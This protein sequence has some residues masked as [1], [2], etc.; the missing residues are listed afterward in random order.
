MIGKKVISS[1]F[2]RFATLLF[3]VM[4]L[5]AF[6]VSK[7]DSG[8]VPVTTAY[9]RTGYYVKAQTVRLTPSEGAA[10][11]CTTDGTTPTIPESL[12]SGPV[13]VDRSLTLKFFAVDAYGNREEMKTETYTLTLTGGE[14]WAWGG[15]DFGH[16]GDGTTN[17]RLTPA[18]NGF[19]GAVSAAAGMEHSVAL[20]ADGTVW[21][22]GYNAYGQ[23]G[24]GTTENSLVPIQVPGLANVA[25]IDSGSYHVVALKNDGTVWAWGWNYWGQVGDG[26]SWNTKYSPVQV[27]GLTDVV[28]VSAGDMHVLALKSDGTVW[29]WG[30]NDNGQLGLGTSG[31]WARSASPVQ[32]TTV[33]NAAAVSA[34]QTHSAVL[35]S[36]DTVWAWGYNGYGQVGDG[37]T[38][39]RLL[40]VQVIGVANVA[41]VVAAG[42]NTFTIMRDGTLW[43]WGS[44]YWG[45]VGDGTNTDRL[46][47]VKVTGLSNIAA[48]AGSAAI[49]SDGTVW[50]WGYNYNG[51]LGDGTTTCSAT[52]LQVPGLTNA[53]AVAVGGRHTLVIRP[54]PLA[55]DTATLAEGITG[56]PYSVTL[57]A[58]GGS[59]PY[60]WS[61]ADGNLPAGLSLNGPTGEISGT[62]STAG[63][64]SL[65]VQA[66]D[67]NSTS[68]AKGFTIT[69]MSTITAAAGPH[70]TISPS[71]AVT[72]GYGARQAFTITPDA[73]YRIVSVTGCD[74]TLKSGVYTTGPITADC[75]VA[76]S[77]ELNVYTLMVTKEGTGNGT[78]TSSPANINCGASCS[79]A[80]NYGTLVTLTAFPNADSFFAGWNGEGCS[81]TGACVI[82]MDGDR[83]VTA[84]STQYITVTAANGGENWSRGT[85][86]TIRWNYA[87]N[88]GS[89]VKIE[90][91][92]GGAV[93]RTITRNTSIGSNG[94]GS[95]RWRISHRLASGPD[96]QIRITSR[97]NSN[98]TDMSNETFSLQ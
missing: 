97:S 51:Q 7:A 61:I 40:P 57:T 13:N 48:A 28:A 80:Y 92:K 10:I 67:A 62:L 2:M 85:T 11:Y 75:S 26:T 64:Y 55:I 35:C 84:T 59:T 38:T 34:G 54:V 39:T 24:N 31:T 63:T 70:G 33:P 91:L 16:L 36:D 53:A 96:Y 17:A 60:T 78:V 15:N 98:Y 89:S 21:A 56:H 49:S 37:T 32:V 25:A 5:S 65:S 71:G 45:A 23:L 41:D 66:T 22:W 72:A 42:D 44:N 9:P 4:I 8:T 12:C 88:P 52:P 74:G 90:L 20:K 69:V 76:A 47:P 30:R 6:N 81:G 18:V 1:S 82:A 86:A 94:S 95:Y 87:G 3:V 19:T 68:V 50:R 14:V 93:D 43:G 73:G 77:F 83:S 27:T 46:T 29:T 79:A 58:S